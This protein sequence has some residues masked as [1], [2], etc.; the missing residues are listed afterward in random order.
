MSI[1][2]VPRSSSVV[3]NSTN[4]YYTNV[5]EFTIDCV[6]EF[7]S[8]NLVLGQ[9]ISVIQSQ[10]VVLHLKYY[11]ISMVNTS[12]EVELLDGK[13]DLSFWK[14][15]MIAHLLVTGLKDVLEE[16]SSPFASTIKKNETR[17][18]TRD[19]ADAD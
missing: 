8:L 3:L 2:N 9:T 17:M 19:F 18:H 16:C 10:H 1:S 7:V 15:R 5:D 6:I 13:G 14:K 4:L 11:S 12:I